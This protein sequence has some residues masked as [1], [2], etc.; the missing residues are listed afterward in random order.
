MI[1]WPLAYFSTCWNQTLWPFFADASLHVSMRHTRLCHSLTLLCLSEHCE[2]LLAFQM[3][4]LCFWGTDGME[5]AMECGQQSNRIS[6]STIT[7]RMKHSYTLLIVGD[8][9]LSFS[10]YTLRASIVVR[11][12]HELG[13]KELG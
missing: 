6:I 9:V 7:V 11:G 2:D 1:T 3:A 12:N 4:F 8:E 10:A 13:R 5:G